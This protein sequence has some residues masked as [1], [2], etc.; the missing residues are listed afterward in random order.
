MAELHSEG[1]FR[2]KAVEG[3][4]GHANTGTEQIAVLFELETGSRLTWYGYLTEKTQERTLEALINCGVTDLETLDGLGSKDVELVIQHEDDQNGVARARVAF[5]NALGSGGVAM[6]N[7][8]GEGARRSV[9][10]RLKG[11]FVKMQREHGVTPATTGRNSRKSAP[12][13]EIGA[14]DDIP[15]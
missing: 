13:E 14:D 5:V 3:D 8:M 1:R 10:A 2:A 15:F 11:N 7:K 9:A 12:A 6:K 4:Y